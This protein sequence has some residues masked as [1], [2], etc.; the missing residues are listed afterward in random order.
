MC[1]YFLKGNCKFGTK[2]ALL[3]T[4]SPQ[5]PDAR[6]LISSRSASSSAALSRSLGTS[7]QQQIS[8]TLR[9]G[10]LD[11]NAFSTHS[12]PSIDISPFARIPIDSMSSSHNEQHSQLSANLNSN[13]LGSSAPSTI[14]NSHFRLGQSPNSMDG[15]L[16]P[17]DTSF[18]PFSGRRGLFMPQHQTPQ[19][20]ALSPCTASL[21]KLDGIP[22]RD[23]D[24][25]DL[26]H[27]EEEDMSTLIQDGGST[28][29]SMLPSSLNDLLTPSELQSRRAREQREALSI[30]PS[31]TNISRSLRS[32]SGSR[33]GL[34]L[35]PTLNDQRTY[36]IS[37]S[38]LAP[39]NGT[40][41][42]NLPFYQNLGSNRGSPKVAAM[43]DSP[44]FSAEQGGDLSSSV[45]NAINIPGGGGSQ[46]HIV[47][48]HTIRRPAYSKGF[49]EQDPFDPFTSGGDDDVQFYMEE[50]ETVEVGI[51]PSV[52]PS[53]QSRIA[54]ELRRPN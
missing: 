49:D 22:E 2:C 19:F 42:W 6:K 13:F 25:F 46:Q 24:Y 50:D 27:D 41:S 37:S 28:E 20:T 54:N 15:H 52:M 5:A 8:S 51:G 14:N 32:Y 9:S 30:T 33:E 23:H 34:P 3:H 36:R 17:I 12:R 16:S 4:L 44:L 45:S 7:S 40:Q 43:E 48:V 47:S 1:K 21:S 31:G 11:M 35:S 29:E 39:T 18:S 26:D 38:P 53:I 10:P